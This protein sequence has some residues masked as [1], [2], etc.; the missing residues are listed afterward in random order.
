MPTRE[1]IMAF[2]RQFLGRW[3]AR[4]DDV[5]VALYR[6]LLDYA[7]GVPRITDS[8]RLRR[9]AW[10]RRALQVQGSLADA[11]NC[12]ASQVEGNVDVLMGTLYPPG[13]QRMNPVGIA[14]ACAVTCLV[15]R[16]GPGKYG[17]KMEARIGKDVF[18]ALA[19]F[20]R[21]SVDVVAFRGHLPYA[22]LSTK[23]GMRHDRIRDPQE[24]ADTYKGQVSGLRFFVVTNEFDSAR[25]GK[26]L[27]YP[28]IDGVFHVRS[29][30]IGEIYRG[31]PAPAP[32]LKDLCDL[33]RLFP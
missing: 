18:P 14:F 23:W 17:W 6:L 5:W 21:K 31:M 33:F 1:E 9:G 10:R 3:V 11:M 27:Q 29:D 32:G 20:R 24:E 22:V 12:R 28:G 8:N 15:Q 25:L 7:H 16:F 2:V 4:P 19:G 30:L 26:L 13:T